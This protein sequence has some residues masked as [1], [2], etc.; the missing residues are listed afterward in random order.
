MAAARELLGFPNQDLLTTFALPPGID[1]DKSCGFPL[2]THDCYFNSALQL[3]FN[4]DAAVALLL[5]HRA[6]CPV[7]GQVAVS[8]ATSG[9]CL[10]C[11]LT[12]L[13][14]VHRFNRIDNLTDNTLPALD[15][16][17]IAG[18]V[19]ILKA[20]FKRLCGDNATQTKMRACFCFGF[21]ARLDSTS[22]KLL[23]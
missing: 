22:S 11:A 10:I 7:D 13:A 23:F 18:Q 4:I 5:H 1:H 16:D 9:T 3:L 12:R 19:R 21:W 20:D 8:S 14:V 2:E 6:S 15:A 17:A